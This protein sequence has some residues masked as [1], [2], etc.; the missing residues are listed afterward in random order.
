LLYGGSASG[1]VV[2][3]KDSDLLR[4]GCGT[5][6]HNTKYSST[7]SLKRMESIDCDVSGTGKGAS[8]ALNKAS[9][10]PTT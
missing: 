1:I 4:D 5:S 7:L 2:E 3:D 10:C 9:Y 6:T 8:Q